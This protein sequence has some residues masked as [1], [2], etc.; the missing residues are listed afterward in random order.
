MTP[1]CYADLQIRHNL[2]HCLY[3]GL[4][5]QN[6]LPESSL[7][8]G[9][10]LGQNVTLIGFESHKFAGACHFEALR[11]S[12]LCF[13]LGHSCYLLFCQTQIRICALDCTT[14][15]LSKKCLTELSIQTGRSLLTERRSVRISISFDQ[16]QSFDRVVIC[17]ELVVLRSA[18]V[19]GPGHDLFG[20]LC[21]SITVSYRQ[22]TW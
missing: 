20:T 15:G 8:L 22:E 11:S 9:G 1:C 14:P 12:S 2:L 6:R 21:P 10:L 3:V 18:A 17:P 19:L 7:P 13:R 4:V 5:C 16:L